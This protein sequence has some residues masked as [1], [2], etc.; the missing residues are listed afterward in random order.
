MYSGVILAYG[1]TG[2]RELGLP[3]EHS[4]K[5][6]LSSRQIVNWYNGSLDRE[7]E[8]EK[9]MNLEQVKQVAIIGNGNVSMDISRVLLKDPSLMAPYDIPS[10]VVDTLRKSKVNVA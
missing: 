4:L 6:V 2:E 1:A 8:I 7:N 5:G 3:K 10:S 9:I